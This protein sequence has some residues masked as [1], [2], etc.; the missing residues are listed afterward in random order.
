MEGENPMKRWAILLVAVATL[1]LLIQSH[2]LSRDAESSKVE[3]D[4]RQVLVNQKRIL[5]SLR[6][7]KKELHIVKIRATR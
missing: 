2:A 3:K 5:D 4:I 1:G 7:I 6:D